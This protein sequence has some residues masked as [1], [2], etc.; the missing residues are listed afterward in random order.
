MHIV[1]YMH[2]GTHP[3]AIPQQD[4]HNTQKKPFPHQHPPPQ[5]VTPVNE[6]GRMNIGSRPAKRRTGGSIDTLRAIPWI[7][8]WTQIRFHLPVW[9]GIGEALKTLIQEGKLELL[10][11]MYENWIFFRVTMDMIEVCGWCVVWCVGWGVWLVCGVKCVGWWYDQGVYFMLLACCCHAQHCASC[12]CLSILYMSF[13]PRP[14][15]HTPHPQP[16]T[17]YPQPKPHPPPTD[18]VCQGRP[19]SAAAV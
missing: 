16:P 3:K 15:P 17:P 5:S 13:H 8:A 4:T 10:E 12:A 9:L 7:F 14:A 19:P 11:D 1:V 2:I 18:G 6:L